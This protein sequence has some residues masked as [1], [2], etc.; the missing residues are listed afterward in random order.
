MTSK[1]K[2]RLRGNVSIEAVLKEIRAVVKEKTQ[3]ASR[4][5]SVL[6]SNFGIVRPTNM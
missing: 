2:H 1:S 4:G 6:V 5:E 3:F